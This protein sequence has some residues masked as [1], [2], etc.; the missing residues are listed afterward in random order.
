METV[1]EIAQGRVW[2][3]KDAVEI[4]LV[5]TLGGLQEAIAAAAELAEL[6][7]YNLVDY[8]KYEE[9]FESMLL[10]AFAEAQVKLFQHPLENIPQNLSN[11]ADWKEFKPEFL[12][13]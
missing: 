13:R 5:D 6:D 8:P 12:I 2:S 9:D 10:G 3:G 4:G 11:L 7:K 1:E